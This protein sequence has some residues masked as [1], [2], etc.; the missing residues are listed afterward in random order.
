MSVPLLVP[1]FLQSLASESRFVA[2]RRAARVGG[3]RDHAAANVEGRKEEAKEGEGER[4]S[5][6][7]WVV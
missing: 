6:K 7:T 3:H 1:P 5:K 4:K 2:A